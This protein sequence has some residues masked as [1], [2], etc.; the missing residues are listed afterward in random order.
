MTGSG[1]LRPG[2]ADVVG[3]KTSDSPWRTDRW[4]FNGL[5]ILMAA[6]LLRTDLLRPAAWPYLLVPLLLANV[7]YSAASVLERA[8]HPLG[9]SRGVSQLVAFGTLL[10]T[11]AV[12]VGLGLA[13]W[14]SRS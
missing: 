11:G 13:G 6:V 4:L 5:L 2:S 7:L 10:V 9:F 3:R 1:G 14:F 8:L 12:L